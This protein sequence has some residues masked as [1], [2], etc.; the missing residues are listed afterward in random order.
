MT[1]AR[2]GHGRATEFF[3]H[4]NSSIN[5]ALL[6][7]SHRRYAVHHRRIVDDE[8]PPLAAIHALICRPRPRSS[9]IS[10]QILKGSTKAERSD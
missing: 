9:G 4:R 7:R 8:T 10:F 3:L 1:A 5:A 2:T 6:N